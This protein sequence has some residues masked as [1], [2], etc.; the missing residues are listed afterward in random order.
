MGMPFVFDPKAAAGARALIQ[1][2]VSGEQA[3]RLL[4]RR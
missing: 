3:G 2:R 4:R 1:F